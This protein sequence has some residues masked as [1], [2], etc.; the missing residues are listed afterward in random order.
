[1]PQFH[2]VHLADKAR[3]QNEVL[4]NVKNQLE[5]SRTEMLGGTGMGRR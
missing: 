1:M 3:S 4:G 5:K 2:Q